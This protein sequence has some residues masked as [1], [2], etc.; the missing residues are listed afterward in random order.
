MHKETNDDGMKLI[1]LTVTKRR[2]LAQ[3][4]FPIIKST[5]KPGYHL[6]EQ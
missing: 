6:T 4:A 1:Q 3:L 5:R 2:L